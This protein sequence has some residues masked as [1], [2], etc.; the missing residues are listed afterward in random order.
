M[1]NSYKL[2]MK[3]INPENISDIDPK[4][5]SFITLIDGSIIVVDKNIPV[6]INS[7]KKN[8]LT[9][10][11]LFVISLEQSFSI[12]NFY[13]NKKVKSYK[14][15]SQKEKSKR[16]DEE[17]KSINNIPKTRLN[18]CSIKNNINKNLKPEFNEDNSA[19]SIDSLSD[20]MSQ[21]LYDLLN[22]SFIK[23]NINNKIPC[24]T[25]KKST[26]KISDSTPS[27]NVAISPN[28]N[29]NV[30]E[31]EDYKTKSNKNINNKA[32]SFKDRVYNSITKNS[33]NFLNN[34]INFNLNSQTD[35]ERN[36][37]TNE[38][39][40]TQK[41]NKLLNK[42]HRSKISEYK[43]S[44]ADEKQKNFTSIYKCKCNNFCTFDKF[45]MNRNISMKK[46]SSLTKRIQML[47]DKSK[48]N[49]VYNS[50]DDRIFNHKKY[51]QLKSD[52]VLPSNKY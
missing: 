22:S 18:T 31:C 15:N 27:N 10:S 11:I 24:K 36:I 40:M 52:L 33:N 2:E 35:E 46:C 7:A 23:K 41:F 25:K 8:I 1:S 30:N 42:I 28:K 44:F 32:R 48:N 9:N 47:Q 49:I 26:K 50:V 16:I 5:I 37:K 38:I 21:T 39:N 3:T 6:K 14:D 17:E 43:T 20:E 51:N 19:L 4:K 13:K 34:Y 29:I 12:N 45:K